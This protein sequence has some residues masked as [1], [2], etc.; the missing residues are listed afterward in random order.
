MAGQEREYLEMIIDFLPDATFVIDREGKVIAWNRAMAEMTG[1]SAE[2]VLGKGDFE[3]AIPFYG[4]RKPMLANLVFLPDSE[5]GNRYHTVQRTGDTL[6]VDIYIPTFQGRGA[7]FWAKASPLYDPQ[8]NI[9]GAI[10][11]IRDIT[12]RKRAEQ[13]MEETRKRLAEIIDFLP[14]ATFV[15]DR[16]GKVIAWNRAMAEMTGVSA[17]EVLGK[18]DFEY[19]IPFYG[20]RKPMLA[21]LVFLPDSEIEKRYHS[22]QRIGDTLVV[23]IHIPAF[24]GRGAYFWA[25]ASPL[26]D[27]QGNI[28]GAIETIRDITDRKRAEQDMEE[29][30]KRLAEIIDFLPDATFVIDREGKAIAWNRAMAEMTGVSAEE[31]LGKGD[32]EYA[33]P[34]Y[35]ERKPMLANLVF[36]PDREI[37]KRYHSIQ[38]IGDTLVVDIHIPAFQGRGAYFWAKAS[39]LYDPQGNITGA[40]ETIRDITDRRAMEERLARSNAELRIAAEIQQSFL[41]EVIPQVKGFDIAARSVMAR[42]VGG[43][44]F[45]VIPFE[46]IPL[47]KGTLG[48]MIADV[49]GKGVPAA[50]FMALSRIVVRVIALWNRDPARVIRDAND[51]ISKDS[52]GGMFVTLFYGTLSEKDRTLEY[53]NAGHN[54]PLVYRNG[55][56]SLEMLMPTG[57]VM[58]AAEH[59]NYS[60]RTIE[61]GTGDVVVLYTDGI[62]ESINPGLEMFG[63]GR[64]KDLIRENA[65]L[66]STEILSKILAS[67]EKFSRGEPQFDDITLMV[68]KGV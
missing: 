34:F 31:V 62:T 30:R 9:T 40:I 49:A 36:L 2:E 26:Y 16:E 8:G 56:G 18:G 3:Y 21:N 19:A 51:V 41:P 37:E 59:Q 33:I 48:I 44:F 35:G 15:I 12:D 61:I 42:E 11:T 43:D 4:E 47:E 29:T 65:R 10:E 23:D 28:T 55:D 52:K 45:D 13:D 24:Q 5:I 68:I 50:L 66:S 67:V 39:P 58:G 63:D 17:E 64:L 54:P 7:Y 14:D 32:F 6:V 46:I 1:V 53:V 38:R 27:P 25:K 60:S 22:I 57:I 20:E